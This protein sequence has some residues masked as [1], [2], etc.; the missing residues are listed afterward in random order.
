VIEV[1]QPDK[2]TRRRRSKTDTL[3]AEA[4]AGQSS[5]AGP[6]VA[7][8]PVTGRWRYPHPQI[9]RH[10]T[11][12]GKPAAKTSAASSATSPGRSTDHHLPAGSRAV[13]G[14]TSIGHQTR[15]SPT[16]TSSINNVDYS[17]LDSG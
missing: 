7:R 1:N 5:A 6:A 2:A 4:A 11:T 10:R 12:E 9:H 16:D 3:D 8:R 13:S 15:S 14:L 17:E